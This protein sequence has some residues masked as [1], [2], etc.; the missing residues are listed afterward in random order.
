MEQCFPFNSSWFA[1]LAFECFALDKTAPKYF[2][3]AELISGLALT[4]VV[5]TIADLRYKF[6]ISTAFLPVRKTSVV[7]TII[8]GALALLTDHWRASQSRVPAG[9][10]LTPEAWQLLLGGCFFAALATWLWLAFLCPARFKPLNARSFAKSVE[11]YLLRGSPAEL[12]VVGDELAKSIRQIVEHTPDEHSPRPITKT[13]EYALRLLMAMAS[14]KFCRAVVEGAPIFIIKLFKTVD[15]QGKYSAEIGVIA[16]N[17]V[18]AAIENRNS[19]LYSERNFYLSGLEGITRPVTSALCRTPELVR[20]LNILL[21]PEYSRRAT[22]DID[23]WQAFF[24]LLLEVFKVHVGGADAAKPASLHWGYLQ[25]EE[26]Y[27]D[28]NEQ[29]QRVEL[30]L[31]DDLSL[32]LRALGALIKDMVDTLDN[33]EQQGKAYVDH[34]PADIAELIFNLIKAA[35]S[36]R[37]P[38]KVAMKIQR[39]LIWE[40]IL[41]SAQLRSGPGRRVLA[42]VHAKLRA[43]VMQPANLEAAR[44]TGYCLNVMG[45][46]PSEQVTGYGSAWRDLHIEFIAW[47]KKDIAERLK[48]YPAFAREC[49]VDGMSFDAQNCQL[50]IRYVNDDG[51]EG[52]AD[53]LPVDP[54]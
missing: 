21:S 39:S 22:W 27:A 4:L 13:Q 2:G 29:L 34:A 38:R 9:D 24:R 44:L 43:S 52:T 28:L 17:L 36:V 11:K 23:Q 5:W 14:P 12:A 3:F 45:F 10:L 15:K 35:S 7:I 19:F 40:G 48:H 1:S 18:T 30:R 51:S 49:F 26:V 41:N 54:A 25:I 53:Y 33:L 20:Q 31:D 32:R 47:V 46:K 37:Q 42:Q 6:R 8:V 16:K 50:V